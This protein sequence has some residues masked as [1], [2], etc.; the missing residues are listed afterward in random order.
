MCRLSL[1]ATLDSTPHRF[2]CIRQLVCCIDL[3]A[4]LNLVLS[5]FVYMSRFVCHNNSYAI[6]IFVIPRYTCTSQFTCTFFSRRLDIYV[7]SIL[8][9]VLIYVHASVCV[10]ISIRVP[11]FSCQTPALLTGLTRYSL[12]PS[13][14][15]ML[16]FYCLMLMIV[17][18]LFRG[19]RLACELG[20]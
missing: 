20:S 16:L 18:Y 19:P 9:C 3:H 1:H 10:S 17:Y 11:Q 5:R 14:C 12:L 6:S 2:V 13:L 8:V 15:F 4:S 7:I